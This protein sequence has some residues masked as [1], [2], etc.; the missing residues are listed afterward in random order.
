MFQANA[1]SIEIDEVLEKDE[2][3]KSWESAGPT[4]AYTLIVGRSKPS[5]VQLCPWFIDWM[6]KD[7]IESALEVPRKS[8]F[9]SVLSK[10]LVKMDTLRSPI[11]V[12]SLLDK[13]ILH[14]LMHTRSGGETRDVDPSTLFTVKYTWKRC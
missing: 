4:V 7:G 11:D 8:Q 13:V 6:R 10:R 14:E 1:R 9:Y 5:Q 12:M 2:S 3:F